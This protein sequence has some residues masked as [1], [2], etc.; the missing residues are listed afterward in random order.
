MVPAAVDA[1][2]SPTTIGRVRN[3]EDVALTP[4]TYCKYVGKKVIAPSIANPTTRATADDTTKTGLAN[5]RIGSIGSRARRSANTNATIARTETMKVAMI[6]GDPH[7]H[8]C[9]PRLVAKV[10]PP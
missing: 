3:P 10:R 8:V 1:T 7:A 6:C 9:P 2:N 4:R 5:S